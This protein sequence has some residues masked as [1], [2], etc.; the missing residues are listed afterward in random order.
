MAE[1][2]DFIDIEAPPETVFRYLTTNSGITAWLGQYAQLNPSEGGAFIVDIAGYPVRGEFLLIEPPHRIVVSWGFAGSEYLPAGASKVEFRLIPIAHG[3]RVELRH[4]DL[5]DTE[6]PGHAH[7][8][9][10]FLPRLAGATIRGHAG[11]DDWKPLREKE[12]LMPT[13]NAYDIVM[14]YHRAWTNGNIDAA[15][16][17]IADDI[18]CS[19]P[20]VKL[21]GKD[22]Y[23]EFIGR[24]APRLTGIGDI[25]DFA[26]DNRIALFYYPQTLETQTAAAAEFFTVVNGKIAR[27]VLIFDRLS[28]G[29][30][31]S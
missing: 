23:R 7:G 19:A 24:F 5:P 20:G 31:K 29:A 18:V 2:R 3:T 1:F 22:Q 10:H 15:M 16:A 4:Y 12:N 6:V 14:N 11:D 28:Y 13:P 9:E 27:S 8:W 25:A 21:E 26:D 30:P 17:Y